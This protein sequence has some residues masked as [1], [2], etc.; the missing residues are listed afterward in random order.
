MIIKAYYEMPW[1]YFDIG[2]VALFQFTNQYPS[3]RLNNEDEEDDN[4]NVKQED[5]EDEVEE[6]AV[7][8]ETKEE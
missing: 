7:K 2:M 4:D 5:K 8:E 6:E 1:N 3:K